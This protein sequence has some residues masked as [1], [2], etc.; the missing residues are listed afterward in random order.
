MVMVGQVHPQRRDGHMAMGCGM[1]VRALP[2]VHGR[3]GSANPV[4]GLATRVELG[5]DRFGRMPTPQP[6]QT[7]RLDLRRWKIGNVDIEQPGPGAQHGLRLQ[8]L[9]QLAGLYGCAVQLGPA[10]VNQR[11][12]NGRDAK[13]IAFHGRTHRTRVQGVIPH[14]GPVVDARH[15][16]VWSVA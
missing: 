6:A 12:R 9:D 15:H 11:K 2:I 8:T 13:Q 5:D 7:R 10:L 14:I 16:Q 1:E 4:H 3:A